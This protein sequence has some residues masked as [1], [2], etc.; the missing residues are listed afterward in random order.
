MP[1]RAAG[2]ERFV[3]DSGR[4][5]LRCDCGEVLVLLGRAEDWL[6]EGHTEFS[7]GGCG[8]TVALG[9]QAREGH[10]VPGTPS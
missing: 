9:D 4:I 6:A 5:V 3:T 2:S 8:G 7:C 10:R 1:M